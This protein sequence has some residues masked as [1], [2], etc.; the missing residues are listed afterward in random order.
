[1]LICSEWSEDDFGMMTAISVKFVTLAWSE[2]ID[3]KRPRLE[4]KF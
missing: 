2:A 1:M 3:R 4:R